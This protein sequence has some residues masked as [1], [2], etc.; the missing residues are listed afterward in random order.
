M[1]LYSALNAVAL[2]ERDIAAVS[3]S[4]FP[5]IIPFWLS[6]SHPVIRAVVFPSSATSPTGLLWSLA[7]ATTSSCIRTPFNKIMF[8]IVS[9]A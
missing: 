3:Y 8:R 5:R 6:L 9:C 4:V 1:L 2:R 7:L